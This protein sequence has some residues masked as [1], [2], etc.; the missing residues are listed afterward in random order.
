MVD[1]APGQFETPIALGLGEEVMNEVSCHNLAPK[2]FGRPQGMVEFIKVVLEAPFL[3]AGSFE[4]MPACV[5]LNFLVPLIPLFIDFTTD[6]H[7][8]TLCGHRQS[9]E[10]ATLTISSS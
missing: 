2:R 10:P 8:A 6:N 9:S 1:I 5:S 7:Q 4:W 3:R